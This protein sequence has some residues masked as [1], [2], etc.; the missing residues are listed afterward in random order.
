MRLP[1]PTVFHQL[2]ANHP[3]TAFCQP[4]EEH[5]GKPW[6]VTGDVLMPS[7]LDLI[8]GQGKLAIYIQMKINEICGKLD[9]LSCT[10]PS[11]PTH[12]LTITN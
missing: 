10:P 6:D 11:H 7:L 3:R 9:P 2:R 12:S 8:G 1:E 5:L 4:D